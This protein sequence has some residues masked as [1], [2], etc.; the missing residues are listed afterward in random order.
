MEYIDEDNVN[1]LVQAVSSFNIDDLASMA[2]SL[3]S[4]TNLQRHITSAEE[5][6][7]G[8]VDVAVITRSEGFTWIKRKTTLEND[9]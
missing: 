1:G 2:E 7:G 8:P 3:I 4:I 9:Y 6:V 5:S